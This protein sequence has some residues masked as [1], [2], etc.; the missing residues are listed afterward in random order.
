M[1]PCGQIN[2]HVGATPDCHHAAFNQNGLNNY[3]L[4]IQNNYFLVQSDKTQE[5]EFFENSV[6]K[7]DTAG[8]ASGSQPHFCYSFC[9]KTYFLWGS[10]ATD[11]E[12]IYISYQ[13]IYILCHQQVRKEIKANF[14]RES[15][16]KSFS[17][18]L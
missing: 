18:F 2:R 17:L 1:Q 6:C 7:K 4:I 12:I 13:E 16:L 15:R 10:P 3:K 14:F 9:T 8:Y 5:L 11:H